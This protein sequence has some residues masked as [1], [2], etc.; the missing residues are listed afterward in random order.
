MKNILIILCF[1]TFNAAFANDGW[2]NILNEG[3]NNKGIICTDAIQKAIEKASQKGGGTIFF[4]AGEYLTGALKLKSNIT[5]YLDSGALL[6]FSDNFDDYLPFVEMRYEGIVMQSFSPLFYAKDAENITIK[7]RGV[8]DGQGKAWWNEVYRIETAKEPL[9]LTK[10]QKMWEEQNKGLFTEPYYK[11][12]IDKKFFRPSFFQTYNCKNILVEG[13]TFQNSPFWTINPEFCD[14]VTITGVTIF[15]PHSP[16]T[17]GINPSSCKN[18][19][20]SNC[21]IS[22]GDDCITIKSGR[23]RDGRKY[24]RATENVTITNCTMLSG[25]GGVVIGSE[26]S[27]GI[28]KVTISNCV[29]DGTDRGIRIKSARGRGGVVEDIRVDNIVMKNIKEEAI[30]LSLFYDKDT[31]EEPVTEKT[32]IFRNIHMSN[33]TGSNVNKAA[34]ILGIKEMPIQNITFSN[35]NMDA[36]EG[37]T[38]NTATEVEFHDVKINASVGSS[39]KISDSKNLILDNTGSS[40][41]IKGVPVIKLDNVSNMMI[42]NN[43]PFTATD[44][45]MEADGKE[46][47]GIYLK[48]NVFNNVNT[49]VKKGAALDKKAISEQP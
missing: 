47:K 36:K 17:D 44:I 21:H 3:G 49:I 34:S 6:K 33:I 46:T 28:K 12:T 22:V 1:I 19:H 11:R 37:F 2:L 26:M 32:P 20:I 43:F 24:A 39:F 38:V 13:V 5:I 29:F 42:N 27:G 8:I 23:D 10:Y 9:P 48:N 7:G 35:I 18:V 16:N 25:H 45:F 41:P 15:N 30:V 4:P 40:T 14:N 31:K